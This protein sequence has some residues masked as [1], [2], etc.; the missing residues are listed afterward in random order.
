MSFRIK[1]LLAFLIVAI[2][3]IQS[4]NL[5][6]QAIELNGFTGFQFGGKIKFYD[7]EFKIK[8]AQNYCGK[9]AVH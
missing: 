4:H 8:D 7:G 3:A 2:L 9:L 1:S 5:S 6:G